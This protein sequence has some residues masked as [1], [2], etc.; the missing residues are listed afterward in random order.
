MVNVQQAFADVEEFLQRFEPLDFLTQFS[1]TYLFAPEDQFASESHESHVSARQL[2][3]AT[4]YYA[5]RPL[6][7]G[8][9]RVDGAV[10]EAFKKLMDTFFNSMNV[11]LT[12]ESIN[13]D[14]PRPP[15][16]LTSAKIHSLHVRG[17]AYPHQFK[18]LAEA[19]Y[20]PHDAWFLDR[21]GFTIADAQKIAESFTNELNDRFHAR[22]EASREEARLLVEEKREDWKVQGLSEAE[23]LT[24]AGVTLLFGCS[25]DLYRFDVG[26]ITALSGVDERR[27]A[28][29]LARL[30]QQP[31][32]RNPMFP[33]TF[34]AAER[35]LWDYNTISECPLLTD[36]EG[37]WLISPHSLVETLY[38][39]FYFDLMADNSYKPTF[40][41]SRGR[42]LEGLVAEYFRRIFPISS[43]HLNPAYPNGEE[44]ADVCVIF[45]GKILVVQCKGKTLTRAAHIGM[46]ETALRSDVQKAIKDAVEQGV[47]ARRFLEGS[48][49]PHLL[50]DGKKVL[51]DKASINEVD[52]VAVTYMPLHSMATRIKEVE[53][54]LGLAHSEYPAW[55]LSIGDL[56]LVT[57]LCDSPAKL[58]H[59]LRRRMMLEIGPSRIHGDEMDLLG[60]YID[61]GL[62]FRGKEFEGMD[63]IAISGYSDPIDEFVF[64][65]YACEGDFPLPKTCRADGFDEVIASI[66]ALPVSRRTDCAVTLLDFSGTASGQLV[67]ALRKAKELTMVDGK[68]HTCSLGGENIIPG[69]SFVTAPKS[70]GK[71]ELFDRTQAFGHLKKYAERNCRWVALG[72]LE[73]SP[74]QVDFA[75][76]LEFPF[77]EN[78][79]MDRAVASLLVSRHPVQE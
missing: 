39:T 61:Q 25:K 42:V 71:N 6:R 13:N 45:D 35:A 79:Q 9:E 15:F 12:R 53:E 14:A 16:A 46:S 22:R 56:D 73:G 47:K 58:L 68:T 26:Q 19:I 63:V 72:W 69:V 55:A 59:Y 23:A 65:K 11:H 41:A 7:A 64:R 27:C 57:Q 77:I 4:G 28:K 3:F 50:I 66:E 18:I 17:D 40:E 29:F 38:S 33:D 43:V 31:P 67:K 62:W 21:L 1:M 54:D 30:S 52:L 76:W 32:Y 34:L 78:E 48:D 5:T 49:T 24:A 75:F 2:E 8:G 44:F 70:L 10:L 74:S 36:G 20:S 37:F 51:I 60:F